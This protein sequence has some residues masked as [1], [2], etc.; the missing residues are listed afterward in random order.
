MSNA[1]Q[2][3]QAIINNDNPE[4]IE[5]DLEFVDDNVDAFRKY[6]NAV[7]EHVEG[8]AGQQLLFNSGLIT[9]EQLK[10]RIMKYDA[11]RRSAHNKA[12]DACAKLNRLCEQYNIEKFCPEI[13]YDKDG[14][15]I[16]RAEVADFVGKY[17]Y[18]VYQRG[19]HKA[20]IQ[21]IA[22]Q[23]DI[24]YGDRTLMDAAFDIAVDDHRNPSEAYSKSDATINPDEGFNHYEDK[25]NKEFLMPDLNF[26]NYL[27]VK[28]D[29]VMEEFEYSTPA[30][31]E[32]LRDEYRAVKLEDWP[33]I[34]ANWKD[35]KSDKYQDFVNDYESD[36]INGTTCISEVVV[37]S[38]IESTINT[39]EKH[40]ISD[41]DL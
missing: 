10:D 38:D 4:Y 18:D 29:I 8:S 14:K 1:I 37:E 35:N 30:Q 5:D 26:N 11:D 36:K 40:D 33:D 31:K 16:N 15:A 39:N 32:A 25:N 9:G 28:H 2:L 6:F 23:K 19:I 21:E 41:I 20:P 27:W 24:K 7:Y 22:K 17:V 13:Q 34:V 12:I 3:K